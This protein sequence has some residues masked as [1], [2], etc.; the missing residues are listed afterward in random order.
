ME[1]RLSLRRRWHLVLLLLSRGSRHSAAK[2]S[3]EVCCRTCCSVD[4]LA[5]EF[6]ESTEAGVSDAG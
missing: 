1:S 6:Q 4:E 2:V 3:A 5:F